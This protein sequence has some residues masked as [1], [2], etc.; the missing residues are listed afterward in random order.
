MS[1]K[2]LKLIKYFWYLN[3]N[4]HCVET[5][6]NRVKKKKEKK[7]KKIWNKK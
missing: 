4:K 5:K 3:L 6:A 2:S 1:K 7:E